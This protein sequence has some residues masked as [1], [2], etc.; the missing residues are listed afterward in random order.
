M[1]RVRAVVHRQ[2]V[3]LKDSLHVTLLSTFLSACL[4]ILTCMFLEMEQESMSQPPHTLIYVWTCE[5]MDLHLHTHSTNLKGLSV[6]QNPGRICLS[7]KKKS[8]VKSIKLSTHKNNYI[9]N[10]F[11]DLWKKERSTDT[12]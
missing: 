4:S 11:R 3:P 12:I 8:E 9:N 1:I 2:H 5:H 7:Q 6:S 10:A